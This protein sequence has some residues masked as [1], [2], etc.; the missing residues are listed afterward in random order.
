MNN[1]SRGSEEKKK[2]IWAREVLLQRQRQL[3]LFGAA[4]GR[5]VGEN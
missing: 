2:P 5:V 1:Q 3:R 4:E